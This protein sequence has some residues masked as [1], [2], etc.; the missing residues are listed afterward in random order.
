MNFKNLT[1]IQSASNYRQ[2]KHLDQGL[3]IAIVGASN[4]GKST[5]LNILSRQN[6]LAKTSKTPGK[7]RL[8]NLFKLDENKRLV[9]L[10][11]Y[12][13]AKVGKEI[14]A[15]WQVTIHEY[16]LYRKSLQALIIIADIRHALKENDEKMII[17]AKKNNLK[18]YIIFTKT[19]KLSKN[20][21]H[22]KKAI[23][24]KNDLIMKNKIKTV[25][26]SALDK[27]SFFEVDNFLN[28][29]W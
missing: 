24:K 19:D 12:G 3:E 26:Y 7:T 16:L 21:L 6:K 1:F 8:I 22:K 13:Y 18:T 27:E 11:G 23:L 14:L 2:I 5:F 9:D 15:S 17:F 28:K 25:C 4:A 20:E 10:P 29:I